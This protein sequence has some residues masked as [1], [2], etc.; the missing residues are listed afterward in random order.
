MKKQTYSLLLI[1]LLISTP[2]MQA[3]AQYK[4]RFILEK[5]RTIYHVISYSLFSYVLSSSHKNTQYETYVESGMHKAFYATQKIKTSGKP[6]KI[7]ELTADELKLL[8]AV[9]NLGDAQY[10]RKSKTPHIIEMPALRVLPNGLS[11][12][13][14]TNKET[15]FLDVRINKLSRIPFARKDYRALEKLQ[16]SLKQ[17]RDQWGNTYTFVIR[18]DSVYFKDNK[19]YGLRKVVKVKKGEIVDIK[20]FETVQ[21]WLGRNRNKTI[22]KEKAVELSKAELKATQSL[23]QFINLSLA[24][25][26]QRKHHTSFSDR[27]K[28]PVFEINQFFTNDH[29]E[30]YVL[31]SIL[32]E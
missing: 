10:K 4:P 1:G 13:Q 32:P 28:A 20:A 12:K 3:K 29:I 7:R 31:E 25:L 9:G 19:A 24:V 26:E 17:K 22:Y 11:D 5:G 8:P 23:D 21:N 2:F 27:R 16:K 6:V 30:T 18:R 15:Q 14:K